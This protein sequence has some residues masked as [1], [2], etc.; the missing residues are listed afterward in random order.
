MELTENAIWATMG[1]PQ[2]VPLMLVGFVLY[3]DLRI[4]WPI[5]AQIQSGEGLLFCNDA[6]QKN[7]N[8]CIEIDL[9]KVSTLHQHRQ[10]K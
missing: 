2:C 8:E 10:S 9:E 6:S 4:S 3:F 5:S 1:I 7:I